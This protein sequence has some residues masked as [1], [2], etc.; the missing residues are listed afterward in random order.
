MGNGRRNGEKESRIGID[1]CASVAKIIR[2]QDGDKQKGGHNR[3]VM[4]I[5]AE[6][7]TRM[8]MPRPPV[9][10][11]SCRYARGINNEH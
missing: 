1:R 6:I 8:I 2:R 11:K 7:M 5:A 3:A 10:R 9:P 4:I